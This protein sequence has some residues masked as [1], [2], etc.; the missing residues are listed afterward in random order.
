[1]FIATQLSQ[2]DVELSC[3]AAN[4]TSKYSVGLLS[5][6]CTIRMRIED[7][8]GICRIPAPADRVRPLPSNKST[9]RWVAEAKTDGKN[10]QT[11]Q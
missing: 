2:L 4:G 6:Y 1:V 3:V 7:D 5:F 8:V 10:K 11:N 9:S